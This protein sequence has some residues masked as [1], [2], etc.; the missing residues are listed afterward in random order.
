MIDKTKLLEA[1][2][3]AGTL[4]DGHVTPG[5]LEAQMWVVEDAIEEALDDGSSECFD[6]DAYRALRRL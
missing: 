1:L 4:F 5:S 2:S 6:W 3:K